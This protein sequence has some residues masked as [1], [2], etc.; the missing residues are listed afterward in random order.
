MALPPHAIDKV[1]GDKKRSAQEIAKSIAES[2]EFLK[3]VEKA[4]NASDELPPGVMGAS[5]SQQVRVAIAN[6]LLNQG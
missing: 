6:D 2:K 4:V 5:F 1:I 3:V